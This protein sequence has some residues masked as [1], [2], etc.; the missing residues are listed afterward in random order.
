MTANSPTPP[1]L[2]ADEAGTAL[3]LATAH[4]VTTLVRA[5][6]YT[7]LVTRRDGNIAPAG[8]RELGLFQ[9]DTRFLSRYELQLHGGE[10]V[11][12]SAE[13]S[14]DSLNQID[15]MVSAPIHGNLDDPQNFLHMRRHQLVDDDGL[16]ER[17]E[18]TSFLAEPLELEMRL[19][20]ASDF[21][22]IFEVRGAVRARRGTALPPQVSSSAS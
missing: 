16:F 21:A 10:V 11:Y 5:A 6:G 20:F 2:P 17:I 14:G 15:Q 19:C 12:L 13:G 3:Q 8:A 7:F 9:R 22:D 4:D 1:L 18:L